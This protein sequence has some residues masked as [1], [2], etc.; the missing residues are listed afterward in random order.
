MAEDGT[1][2]FIEFGPGK[3]LAGLVRRLRKDARVLSVGDPDG[4]TAALAELAA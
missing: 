3:I 2:T 4:V 1:T